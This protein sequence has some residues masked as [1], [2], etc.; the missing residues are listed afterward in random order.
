MP[1]R[2]HPVEVLED[3]AIGADQGAGADVM[4]L[5]RLPGE[6]RAARDEGIHELAELG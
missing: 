2:L 5:H 3:S 6:G 1:E 4:K